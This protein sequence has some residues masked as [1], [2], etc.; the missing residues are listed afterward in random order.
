VVLMVCLAGPAVTI[1][2]HNVPETIV[3]LNYD[4][5][6]DGEH[7][8]QASYEV[9]PENIVSLNDAEAEKDKDPFWLSYE[10]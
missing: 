9:F 2:L 10:E 1:E 8:F 7:P 3:R 4:D 6:E 5:W